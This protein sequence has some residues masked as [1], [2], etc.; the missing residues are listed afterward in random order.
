M[1]F[2][3]ESNGNITLT[4][5]SFGTSLTSE[6]RWPTAKGALT[7][8][9]SM[10]HSVYPSGRYFSTY[11]GNTG[12]AT[13]VSLLDTKIFLYPFVIDRTINVAALSIRVATAGTTGSA[14][15]A[16][17]WNDGANGMPTG[18][19][20]SGLGNNTST[21]TTSAATVDMTVSGK[22]LPGRYW[23]GAAFTTAAPT[24]LGIGATIIEL[25]YIAGRA[26]LGTSSLAGL[27]ANYTYANDITTLDLTSATFSDVSAP[28]GNPVIYL[29]AA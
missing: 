24:C 10:A 25:D 14:V 23:A 28:Q 6:V 16:A 15:K 22:L 17:I 3:D 13:A 19:P 9:G 5:V 12:T 7:I 11:R 2:G 26:A 8:N 1:Y 4:G 21:A 20:I 27:T 29:K 18:V